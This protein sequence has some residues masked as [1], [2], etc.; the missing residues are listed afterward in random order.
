[1]TGTAP[2][3]KI[4]DVLSDEQI[5]RIHTFRTEHNTPVELRDI[6][7][8]L[9]GLRMGMR[10]YDVLSLRFQDIDWKKRQISIIMKKPGLRSPFPCLLKWAMRYICI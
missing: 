7:I 3:D 8:V 2:C 10:A 9:L 6:A 5:Q 1:M 4:I